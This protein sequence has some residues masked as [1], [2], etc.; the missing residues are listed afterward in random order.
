LGGSRIIQPKRRRMRIWLLLVITLCACGGNHEQH[1]VDSDRQV[2]DGNQDGPG[3]P[4]SPPVGEEP[5]EAPGEVVQPIPVEPCVLTD[6]P[7]TCRSSPLTSGAI[8]VTAEVT[9]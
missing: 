3:A 1:T 7:G 2:V 5:I 8:E 9:T 6:I 4:A